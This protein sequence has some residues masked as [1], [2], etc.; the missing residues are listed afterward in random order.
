MMSWT[1]GVEGITQQ[2]CSA[3][4]VHP[5]QNEIQ[6]RG[7]ARYPR[8][9]PI[10]FSDGPARLGVPAL[11]ETA[12]SLCWVRKHTSFPSHV[13]IKGLFPGFLRRQ[14][15]QR[16]RAYLWRIWF[17]RCGFHRPHGTRFL[18]AHHGAQLSRRLEPHPGGCPW[19]L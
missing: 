5:E 2:T 12:L 11:T 10:S 1:V 9:T 13:G 6:P 18:P 16:T 8:D 3:E 19:S 15:A 14:T 4:E 7:Q 17:S